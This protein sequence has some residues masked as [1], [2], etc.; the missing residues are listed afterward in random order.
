MGRKPRYPRRRPGNRVS[1]PIFHE[2]ALFYL[3]DV[4]ASQGDTEFTGTAAE[5]KAKMRLRFELVKGKRIPGMRIEKP[6]SLVAIHAEKPLDQA[7]ETATT[8][9]MD[10]LISEY[11][12]SP[13]DAY[14]LV[15]P[16]PTFASTSTR[17]AGSAICVRL[18]G[19]RFPKPICSHDRTRRISRIMST[20]APPQS[21]PGPPQQWLFGNLKEFGRDRLGTLSRWA[22]EY[23]DV[24]WAR[25]ARGTLSSSIIPT[26]LKRFW[27]TRIGSSSSITA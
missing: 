10:W 11:G 2:G 3:G 24:V 20:L 21:P 18:P 12:F 19:P 6:G 5:T 16:V 15:R 23:G 25:L 7:V 8:H 4:H 14:C 27:L 9:L 26:W 1:L 17:C 22:Q 13:V